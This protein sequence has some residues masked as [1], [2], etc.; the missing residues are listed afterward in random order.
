[1]DTSNVMSNNIGD[2]MQPASQLPHQP[3]TEGSPSSGTGRP[4]LNR[5][6]RLDELSK[7]FNLPE[8]AVAKE[9]GICL[10]SLKK[11][12]RSYG[13]TRWPFRKLK[14]LQRT[15]KKVETESQIIN[16][17]SSNNTA[18]PVD[19]NKTNSGEVRRKPYTV[20][21]KTVFLSDEELEVYKM[22]M[23]KD[24]NNE[25]KPTPLVTLEPS[26]FSNANMQ[27]ASNALASVA[28]GSGVAAGAWGGGSYEG[29]NDEENPPISAE[30]KGR[31][32]LIVNWSSLWS[33]AHLK[34][35][36]LDPLEGV[37]LR[38]SPDGIRAELEFATE[39]TAKRAHR[40]CQM[41]EVQAMQS[42][43]STSSAYP[44][45]NMQNPPSQMTSVGT[46]GTDS[47]FQPSSLSGSV[48]SL[49]SDNCGIQPPST[50][51]TQSMWTSLFP[52]NPS[53]LP[54]QSLTGAGAPFPPMGHKN[55]PPPPHWGNGPRPPF[56]EQPPKQ[57][58]LL[59][60]I[61]SPP[62]SSAGINLFMEQGTGAPLSMGTSFK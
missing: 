7:F 27:A 9:L 55:T 19:P 10:T 25:L 12:C 39:E 42:A 13:I 17:C 54:P 16:A 57:I 26:L 3:S 38:V 46:A 62:I 18:T 22:T 35:K 24:A 53:A 29:N 41:A 47:V 1:M 48:H 52:G 50:H 49:L 8:K 37:S 45:P 21:N 58:G 44:A 33:Q 43:M 56:N 20:G 11:L 60:E 5:E 61:S 23:G 2:D 59:G 32:L 31:T 36:L 30:V 40:I 15:M 14:S 51:M 6:V 28:R 34:I 4:Y